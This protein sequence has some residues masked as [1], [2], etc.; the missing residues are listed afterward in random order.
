[1]TAKFFDDLETRNPEV[2]ERQ[3]FN[4][5]A[6]QLANA[7]RRSGYFAKLL[8][9]IHPHEL[10]GR[11]A[12]AK[13][14]VTRKSDLMELQKAVP[15]FG[16]MTAVPL[17]QLAR[18]FASPGPI[19]EPQGDKRDFWGFARALYAAGF[20]EGELVHNTFSYHFTPAGFM[21]DL[22]AQALGCPV[23]PAG[24]GQTELQVAT[25]AD[26]RPV[27]Y[28]GTPSFLKI[29]LEKAREMGKDVSS[30]KKASVGGEAFL[31][32]VRQMLKE[33]GIASYQS[34]GTADLGLIA[35]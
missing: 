3:L 25:I 30:L 21:L 29:I 28:A 12:L 13:L 23:F 4:A 14:P 35:Y 26:L 19:Y 24:V 22:A 17:A 1:M 20:R 8:G 34:Y 6:D 31:P 2:R 11:A 27:C 32:S 16:A 10:G 18:V 5:L 7:K 15:P 9:G 33:R